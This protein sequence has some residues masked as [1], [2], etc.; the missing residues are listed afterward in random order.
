MSI[1]L[2]ALWK[3]GAVLG[4]VYL[5]FAAGMYFGQRRFLYFPDPRHLTPAAAGL[6]SVQEEVLTAKDG[7]KLIAWYGSARPGKKTLLYFHGNAGHLAE[8]DDRIKAYRGVGFG[9]LIL[10]YRGYSGSGGS[11][12]EAANVADA[13][14]AYDWLRAK[15]VAAKDIVIYGESL[16]TGVA[17][18]VAVERQTGGLI[19]D[20]PY[21]SIADIAASN[22]PLLPVRLL[23]SDPYDTMAFIGRVRAPL[24]VIAGEKDQ[25][26]PAALSRR[27][28]AAANAA[29]PK[30][31]VV[32]PE[33]GHIF[34]AEFGSRELVRDWVNGLR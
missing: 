8:R 13:K 34:H 26:V 22:Y 1:I 24:L 32:Y 31:I 7:V 20:A 17:V 16:G 10:A 9:L 28:F 19:L 2:A 11:P 12:S 30:R 14:L 4:L 6:E 25:I 3:G 23:L 18:Q 29:E 27:V 21:T 5:L 15:G 33:G